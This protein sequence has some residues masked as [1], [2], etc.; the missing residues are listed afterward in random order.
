[1]PYDLLL[2]KKL[3]KLLWKVKI[4]D[5]ELLCEEPH[6]TIWRG[7]KKWRYSLRRHAFLDP[8]PD[9]RE[10]SGEVLQVIAMKEN[11]DELVRQWDA[12]FPKNPVAGEED[13]DD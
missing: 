10:V 3:Q 1:M 4:Q 9:P 12:R 7:K 2:S 8:Q 5:K 6:V 11:Y 13:D